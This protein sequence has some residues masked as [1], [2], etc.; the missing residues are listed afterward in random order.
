MLYMVVCVLLYMSIVCSSNKACY[1]NDNDNDCDYC[2]YL[3]NSETDCSVK[4]QRSSVNEK[5]GSLNDLLNDKC[6][7]FV[8]GGQV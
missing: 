4:H 7:V 8:V 3:D 1:D 6:M 5:T 2:Y